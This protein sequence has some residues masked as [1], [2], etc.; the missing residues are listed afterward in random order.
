MF[1]PY[2]NGTKPKS[3][4]TKADFIEAFVRCNKVANVEHFKKISLIIMQRYFL[5]WSYSC[6]FYGRKVDFFLINDSELAV[7]NTD[8]IAR[9]IRLSQTKNPEPKE[10]K[11]LCSYL[12]TYR[13]PDGIFTSVKKQSQGVLKGNW[14]YLPSGKK[15]KITSRGFEIL[16][17]EK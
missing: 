8:E 17:Q 10:I 16:S 5:K 15:K 3:K 12:E 14:F 4:Y 2:M 13:S 1:I 11:A 9:F 6:D 7:L